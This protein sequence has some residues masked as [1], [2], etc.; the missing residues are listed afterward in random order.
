MLHNYVVVWD[1]S[2]TVE[3]Q[4]WFIDESMYSH[5]LPEWGRAIL[6]DFEDVRMGRKVRV[7]KSLQGGVGVWGHVPRPLP[8]P[9]K[10]NKFKVSEV[11]FPGFPVGHF[12]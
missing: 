6:G 4:G 11:P 9:K 2:I 3:E 8:L 1:L 7:R 10:K 12:Q 5:L